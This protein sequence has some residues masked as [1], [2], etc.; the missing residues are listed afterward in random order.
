MGLSLKQLESFR[1]NLASSFSPYYLF[2]DDP[3]GLVSFLL[4]NKLNNG[5][6]S[7]VKDSP[8]VSKKYALKALSKNA[9]KVVIL[10]KPGLDTDFLK[11]LKLN[12]VWLDHH[13]PQIFEF[14]NPLL[15]YYNPRISN[16]KDGRPTSFWVFKALS[17]AFK[18]NKKDY[19]WLA[20]IGCLGDYYWPRFGV[21]VLKQNIGLFQNLGLKSSKKSFRLDVSKEISSKFIDQIL[22]N[23]RFGELIKLFSYSLKPYSRL[24]RKIVR[25]LSTIDTLEE[26]LDESLVKHGWKNYHMLDR[27]YNNLLQKQAIF[28]KNLMLLV[29]SSKYSMTGMLSNELSFRHSNRLVIVCRQTKSKYICSLRSRNLR[30]DN[31]L[32]KSLVNIK[33]F[34]GGH[35]YA[36]G[37]TIHI[38]DFERF[39]K[40]LEIEISK[41]K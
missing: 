17:K 8:I 22:Y 2:D 11:A 21:R 33:G 15:K 19:R 27:V 34:G 36:C 18:R 31:L 30:V 14:S 39:L 7:C 41:V 3:D 5:F 29:Y 40:N 25:E 4:C 35:E 28:K 10:D 16:L 9:D 13:P 24:M 12:V 32:S 37:A 1:H 20:L 23:S 38:N 6:W 26:L